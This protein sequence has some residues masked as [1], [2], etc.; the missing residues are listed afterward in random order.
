MRR[1][2]SRCWSPGGFTSTRRE[3][4]RLSSTTRARARLIFSCGWHI[5]RDGQD[6]Y[7]RKFK[8]LVKAVSWLGRLVRAVDVDDQVEACRRVFASGTRWTV[9]RGV[10]PRSPGHRRLPHAL[11]AR[12]RGCPGRSHSVVRRT[13]FSGPTQRLEPDTFPAIG[14]VRPACRFRGCAAGGKP[15]SLRAGSPGAPAGN[16]LVV[17]VARGEN[18]VDQRRAATAQ[19]TVSR[20][21]LAGGANYLL[22]VSPAWTLETDSGQVAWGSNSNGMRRR[23]SSTTSGLVCAST[24]PSRCFGTRWR[25]CLLTRTTRTLRHERLW[26]G[27]RPAGFWSYHSLSDGVAFA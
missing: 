23:R 17:A 19:A 18:A 5:T 9:V 26:W 12:I 14:S 13:A 1:G 22:K 21:C 3:R 24:M 8:A 25:S 27:T 15:Q 11:G 7:S 10:D 6:V 16:A 20:F 4:P 2:R